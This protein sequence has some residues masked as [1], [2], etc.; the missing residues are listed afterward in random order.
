MFSLKNL[1]P[2][3]ESDEH[4][5]PHADKAP[6]PSAMTLTLLSTKLYTANS[7]SLERDSP[8]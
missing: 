7:C 4:D 6:Q 5:L 2:N 1:F 8:K 3:F